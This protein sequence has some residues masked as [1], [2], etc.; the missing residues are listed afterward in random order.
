MNLKSPA[1]ICNNFYNIFNPEIQNNYQIHGI[2]NK[3]NGNNTNNG[4][5]SLM[6]TMGTIANEK[7][8]SKSSINSPQRD[9]KLTT[10]KL[11][12]ES[13][14]NETTFEIDELKT[15]LVEKNEFIKFLLTERDNL[16]EKTDLLDKKI[17][18][19]T[20]KNMELIK[21]YKNQQPNQNSSD[22]NLNMIS[23]YSSLNIK[24]SKEKLSIFNKNKSILPKSHKNKLLIPQHSSIASIMTDNSMIISNNNS[25][26]DRINKNTIT[27]NESGQNTFRKT[28]D[29]D[30]Y[31][32]LFAN[33]ERITTIDCC[34]VDNIN[35]DK[36]PIIN[37]ITIKANRRSYS[38][39]SNIYKE[40][41]LSK[42][43]NDD[44]AANLNSPPLNSLCKTFGDFRTNL[45][46][47]KQRTQNLLNNLC[48]KLMVQ[49]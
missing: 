8:F 3:I 42:M 21:L 36:N 26:Y 48:I 23:S 22:P 14:S 31:S 38:H 35:I 9:R 19:I 5:N 39:F 17:Q 40:E 29:K 11:I 7:T 15:L 37:P 49:K 43:E 12:N 25:I 47:I 45:K 28:I 16:L 27:E 46:E 13:S 18:S 6:N 33:R 34:S 24:N 1:Q 32:S 20:F 2:N 10:K 41:V 4:V 44:S 30:N